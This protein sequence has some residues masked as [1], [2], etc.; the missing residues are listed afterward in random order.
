MT[1][2]TVTIDRDP[3]SLFVGATK[4][5]VERYRILL[6]DTLS[7]AL[8]DRAVRVVLGDSLG[9]DCSGDDLTADE[10]RAISRLWLAVARELDA[11]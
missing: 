5:D 6:E 4:A 1:N 11:V 8:P 2:T 9:Y 7:R 10:M 3:R